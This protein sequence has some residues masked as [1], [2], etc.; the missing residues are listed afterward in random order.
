[1]PLAWQ[2]RDYFY[3]PTNEEIEFFKSFIRAGDLCFDVGANIGLFIRV[4]LRAK[5]KV[6][7]IEPNELCTDYLNRRYGK[8]V[9]IYNLA[10]DDIDGESEL[11]IDEEETALGSMSS[12]WIRASQQSGRLKDHKW[13]KVQKVK[14]TTLNKLISAHGTPK[15]IKIDVEGFELN[16]LRGLTH[17][18]EN[19]S[20]EFHPEFLP[21]A[22]DCIAYIDSL[23][24]Y[25]YN[26]IIG[27]EGKGERMKFVGDWMDSE[28][29][30]KELKKYDSNAIYG[31]IFAKQT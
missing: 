14:T 10:L 19:I 3:P 27:E 15:Y 29:L 11:L 23:S 5:A 1:M 13:T 16:V 4:L 7:A 2:I 24:N 31:D 12:N 30:F 28:S 22:N 6:I 21:A 9:S 25:K 8:F 17:A 18:V 26:Y 20:F